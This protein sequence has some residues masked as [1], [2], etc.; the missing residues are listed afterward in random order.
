MTEM[1]AVAAIVVGIASSLT[2]GV[3]WYRSN[4]IANAKAD[5]SVAANYAD[6]TVHTGQAAE[7]QDL[8]TRVSELNSAF[9][10]Q[11]AEQGRLKS[12][13]S[14]LEAMLIGISQHH[15]NLMLCEDCM[16]NNAR[17]LAALNKTLRAA[18]VFADPPDGGPNAVGT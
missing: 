5:A 3:V 14:D 11:A 1:E 7:I 16:A 4:R 12:K 15:D 8:R 9:V 6:E 17:V 13:V 10:S 2:G 18:D